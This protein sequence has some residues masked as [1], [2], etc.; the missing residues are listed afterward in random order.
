MYRMLA[1]NAE[2]RERRNQLRIA[3][4]RP[5]TVGTPGQRAVELDNAEH[6]HGAL[7]LL[8]PYDGTTGG[9]SSA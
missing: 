3:V 7:G 9:P 6:R 5:R 1:A 4:I 2:L 8:T